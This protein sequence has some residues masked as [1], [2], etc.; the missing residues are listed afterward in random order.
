MTASTALRA[1]RDR[2]AAESGAAEVVPHWPRA[3]SH[4]PSPGAMAREQSFDQD[5]VADRD[6]QAEHAADAQ[7]AEPVEQAPPRPRSSGVMLKL[8]I[9]LIVIAVLGALGAVGYRQ[10]ARAAAV[11]AQDRGPYRI[12]Q[13]CPSAGH[14]VT[15]PDHAEPAAVA[16]GRATHGAL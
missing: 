5:A 2:L 16:G 8:V 3:A 4:E 12:E 11:A 15:H 7:F 9:A 14:S 10:H 1:L 6:Q 13:H